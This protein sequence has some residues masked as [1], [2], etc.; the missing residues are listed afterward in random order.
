MKFRIKHISSLYNW[1]IALPWI[2]ILAA[3]ALFLFLG[4]DVTFVF[5]TLVLI[6]LAA[7][8]GIAEVIFIFLY[9]AERIYGARLIINED[10]IVIKTLHRHRKLYYAEIEDAKY[11]HYECTR[12]NRE[13]K[14]RS[15]S[16]L[17]KYMKDEHRRH[18]I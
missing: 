2:V 10:H 15:G 8:C 14:E 11:S 5:P 16:L 18:R 17:Y 3:L 12:S 7:V 13:R 9:I 6:R 1:G 4:L